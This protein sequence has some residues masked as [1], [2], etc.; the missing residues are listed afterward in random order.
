MTLTKTITRVGG[1]T[2]TVDLSAEEEAAVRAGWQTN[3]PVTARV[4]IRKSVVVARLIAAGKI[5]A[6]KAALESNA[7]A[8]A[9]WMAADHP[10][11][12]ADDPDA[13]ALVQNIGADP[14]VILAP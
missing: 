12:Y 1:G 5:E 10:S 9:R 13:I 11:V 7:G 2:E 4:K 8:F 14:A 6:A 3:A